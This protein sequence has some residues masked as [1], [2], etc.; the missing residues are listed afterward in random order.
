[1]DIDL[2]V[3]LSTD[4][5]CNVL[6]LYSVIVGKMLQELRDKCILILY[7]HGVDQEEEAVGFQPSLFMVVQLFCLQ[8]LSKEDVDCVHFR[9]ALEGMMDVCNILRGDIAFI[10]KEYLHL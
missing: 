3:D 9:V 10:R 6:V 8:Q 1:M 4:H 7:S 5:F 2:I